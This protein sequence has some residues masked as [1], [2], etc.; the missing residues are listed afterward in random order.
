[1][2]KRL[3]H[4]CRIWRCLLVPFL[5]LRCGVES[6]SVVVAPD[7]PAAQ[8]RPNSPINPCSC[9]STGANPHTTVSYL[10]L[11]APSQPR[12][13]ALP[14]L[15]RCCSS[16]PPN[17]PILLPLLFPLLKF[18]SGCFHQLPACIICAKHLWKRQTALKPGIP[19][20]PLLVISLYL[21]ILSRGLRV[22]T[23]TLCIKPPAVSPL[24]TPQGLSHFFLPDNRGQEFTP[25]FLSFRYRLGS[26]KP[27][28]DS[29]SHASIQLETCQIKSQICYIHQRWSSNIIIVC[30]VLEEQREI[31]I[32]RHHIYLDFPASISLDSLWPFGPTSLFK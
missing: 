3:S 13:S 29:P 27:F 18:C 12:S 23:S 22:V 9:R 26:H 25:G 10:F 6:F 1:M 5:S 30:L 24:D 4:A 11:F 20:T 28:P 15:S 16:F 7:R 32:A 17:L 2:T 19:L 21:V 8:S 31:D 14:S